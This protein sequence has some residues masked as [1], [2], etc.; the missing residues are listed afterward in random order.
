MNSVGYEGK[1]NEERS[2]IDQPTT[3]QSADEKDEEPEV[4]DRNVNYEKGSTTESSSEDEN[5]SSNSSSEDEQEETS[6]G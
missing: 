1:S 5:D 6:K 4:P 3:F 2:N